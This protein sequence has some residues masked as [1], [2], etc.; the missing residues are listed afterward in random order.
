MACRHLS[1]KGSALLQLANLERFRERS[2]LAKSPK[3]NIESN[4]MNATKN[5]D[6]SK[7]RF[8]GQNYW[9]AHIRI[10]QVWQSRQST[11]FLNVQ[12]YGD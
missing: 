12:N 7:E 9:N 4:F 8:T 5:S 3:L 6:I 10:E 1:K 2:L 11:Q